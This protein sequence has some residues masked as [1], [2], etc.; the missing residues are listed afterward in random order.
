MKVC[1]FDECVILVWVWMNLLTI[2]GICCTD[3]F[4]QGVYSKLFERIWKSIEFELN[5]SVHLSKSKLNRM[6]LNLAQNQ[7]A[8][9]DI[10]R[11]NLPGIPVCVFG[12]GGLSSVS[13]KNTRTVTV[14][15]DKKTKKAKNLLL[16]NT[17]SE[18]TRIPLN[19]EKPKRKTRSNRT[20][21]QET[22]PI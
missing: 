16:T 9:E 15:F 1:I 8:F 13:F 3:M 7:S 17:W 12:E 4:V 19:Q 22:G 20:R 5:R 10:R 6:S 18:I 11:G 21:R 2:R 14:Q